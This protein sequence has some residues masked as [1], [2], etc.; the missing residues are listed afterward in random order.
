VGVPDGTSVVY[1][2]PWAVGMGWSLSSGE[3]RL[4]QVN[5]AH[6]YGDRFCYD[7]QS[8]L[9]HVPRGKPDY[10]VEDGRG[11]RVVSASRFETGLPA[12]PLKGHRQ[13]G[14]TKPSESQ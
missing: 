6:H 9:P 4:I 12:E 10:H 5:Q 13:P 8:N 2:F 14:G 11:R 1:R 3:Y 7:R